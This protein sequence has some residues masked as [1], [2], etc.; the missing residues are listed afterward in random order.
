MKKFLTCTA[1]SAVIMLSGCTFLKN[2]NGIVKVNNTIIT[3]AQFDEAFDKTIDNSI[4]K[5]FGGADNFKKTDD[6]I[7]YNIFKEKVMNELIVKTLLN[8]EIEKRGI[9]VTKEDVENEMKSVVDKVGSKEELNTLLKQRGIS[10]AEFTED[11]RTQVEIKKLINSIQK[12][13]ISDSDAQKYYNTHPAEFKH[14]EQVRASHILISADTLQIIR[15]LKAKNPNISPEDLN[16][17][18]DKILAEQKAK[19]EAILSEVK[20]NPD[21]F[22]Q[23]AQKKSDDRA[24]G[25]RGGELGFFTKE[26]MVPEF[27]KA[28]FSMKPNTISDTIIKS[29]YGYHIIKV[30]DRMEA[31]VTPYAK[32]KDEIKFVL[33]TQKQMAVLKNLTSG[34][35]KSAKIEYI[36]ESFKPGN[37]AIEAAKP[38]KK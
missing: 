7:M 21:N 2:N 30:T 1:I 13:S 23:I 36:D 15:D 6:N 10:N 33:E 27:A 19:A 37:A 25:E 14:G 28:A 12:I 32:V 17:Q 24:S 38:E 34:L 16:K 4:F 22:A 9:K 35:M 5:A 29:P 11:L 31:G 18:V 8:Q 3:Q 26:A 20:A